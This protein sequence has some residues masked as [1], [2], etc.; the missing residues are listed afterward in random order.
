MRKEWFQM[1]LSVNLSGVTL[2][3]PIIA[4][5][6]VIGY[7]YEFAEIFDINLLGGISF[8]GTTTEPRFGNATP[9]IA[10]TDSGMLNSVG[11]QNPGL[12]QVIKKQLPQLFEAYD[13]AI[14]ANIS[15]FAVDE[16]V[17]LAA[18]FDKIERI[19]I[20]ELNISCPNVHGGG[21]AF[22]SNPEQAALVTEAVKKVTSKPLY[23]K[24]SPNVTDISAIA[25]ACADA[26]AD[27]LSLINTLLGMR[28]DYRTGRHILANK[29]GGLSGPAIFPVALRMVYDVAST[30]DIP[31]IG[32]GGIDSPQKVIEMMSAGAAAVQIGAEFLTNP[33][34]Y[35]QIVEGLPS[36]LN[37]IGIDDITKI[38]GRTLCNV[39]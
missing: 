4:A 31:I 13:K 33:Q 5:S 36:I 10:E 37:E 23:V 32:L 6:G 26:G 1:N 27:G 19:D 2:E 34:I 12:E 7:G 20:I 28:I 39:K 30:V 3:N 14:I 18:A 21:M 17:K 22:G 15:G 25:K 35:K 38:T 24:L 11:L 9:R 16:F 29:T 8:K